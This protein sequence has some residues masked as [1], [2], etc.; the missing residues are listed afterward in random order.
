MSNI[1]ELCKAVRLGNLAK[2]KQYLQQ[3]PN[4]NLNQTA[5]WFE[6]GICGSSLFSKQKSS[7]PS[8]YLGPCT[9][10]IIAAAYGHLAIVKL[11]VESG[12]VD[13]NYK[14]GRGKDHTALDCAK[15][16]QHQAVAEY[17]VQKGGKEFRTITGGAQALEV[18]ETA[19]PAVIEYGINLLTNNQQGPK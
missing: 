19:A 1:R 18:M 13:I 4:L 15:G 8:I 11:L 12:R 10:L 17:L 9:P 5:E 2:V 6:D 16:W 14:A 7:V 3:Y